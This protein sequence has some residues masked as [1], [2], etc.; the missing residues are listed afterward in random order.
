ML[1]KWNTVAEKRFVAG[2]LILLINFPL[3][4]LFDLMFKNVDLL[5]EVEAVFVF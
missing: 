4:K 2:R 5:L 1:I 3:L